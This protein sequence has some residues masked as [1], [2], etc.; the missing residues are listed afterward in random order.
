MRQ[1]TPQAMNMGDQHPWSSQRSEI[2][3]IALAG[4]AGSLQAFKAVLGSLPQGLPVPVMICQHRG[5]REP[6]HDMLVEILGRSC[7][8]PAIQACAESPLHPGV[9]Y[10]APPDRHIGVSSGCIILSDAPAI[11]YNRP[12]VDRLF[13]SLAIECG[14]HLIVVVLSGSLSDGA[15]GVIK[16]K[17]SGGRVIVQDPMTA[18][19]A[20][21]PNAAISSGCAD[22]ILPLESIASALTALTMVP[23]STELFPV[24]IPLR[25]NWRAGFLNSSV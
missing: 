8:F 12:S 3:L 16:V 9:V 13:E 25:S 7:S 5:S 1:L 10:V 21:M 6:E 18:M 17:A 22:F 15:K 4:S 11:D 19:H 14:K 23:G 2:R 20:G 24:S